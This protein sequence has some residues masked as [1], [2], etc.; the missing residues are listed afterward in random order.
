MAE[1]RHGNG[2]LNSG[3]NGDRSQIITEVNGSRFITD[4]LKKVED[5][6]SHDK[7]ERGEF[8]E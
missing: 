2:F 7:N 3:R 6:Q 8:K 4:N 1:E 5:Y